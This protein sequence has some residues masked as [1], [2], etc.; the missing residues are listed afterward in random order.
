MTEALQKT[1]R[2][3]RVVGGV[4]AA[5]LGFLLGIALF[6]FIVVGGMFYRTSCPS[7]VSWTF[8]PLPFVYV[9]KTG[10]TACATDTAT[11]YYASKVPVVGGPLLRY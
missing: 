6:V 4:S 1:G 2:A 9:V 7:H 3:I 5:L 11:G 8:S 10:D